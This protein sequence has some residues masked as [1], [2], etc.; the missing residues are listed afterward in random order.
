MAERAIC[1]LL[2]LRIAFTCLYKR[3]SLTHAHL[4]LAHAVPKH[5]RPSFFRRDGAVSTTHCRA[6]RRPK[7]AAFHAQLSEKVLDRRDLQFDLSAAAPYCC[8]LFILYRQLSEVISLYWTL[9]QAS[10][11]LFCLKQ[12]LLASCFH[13]LGQLSPDWLP[14][15]NQR[16]VRA[17]HC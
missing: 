17:R 10:V 12:L 2:E 4:V 3:I 16:Y 6:R 9:L 15:A 11:P 7:A 1:S 13:T 14:L 8:F 5:R